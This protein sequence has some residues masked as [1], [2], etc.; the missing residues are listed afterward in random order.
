MGRII[1]LEGLDGCGKSTQ[2]DLIK[3][4]NPEFVC[5]SFPNYAD[6]SGKI[7][8]RYLAGEFKEEDPLIS[9]FSASSFY[10][11]D[12]YISYKTAW[13]K[14]YKAGKTI[15]AARYTTSNVIY[16]M[17][18]L[19]KSQWEKY[20]AWLWDYEYE[21]L[22]IPKPDKVIYLDVPLEI[23]QKLLTKRY[24]ADGGKKDVHE[25][26]LEFMER[27]SL[28]AHYAAEMDSPRWEV[29]DCTQNGE[30]RSIEDIHREIA[31]H[32]K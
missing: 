29:I 16:Q 26:N 3:A 20:R 15:F 6:D 12:R 23:S 18:K 28:A 30:M 5:V 10:S 24:E 8:S 21:K 31:E 19:D 7:V 27:C 25:A 9:A 14:D 2:F 22:G 1:V 4:E 13:E 11:I 17:A 32:I